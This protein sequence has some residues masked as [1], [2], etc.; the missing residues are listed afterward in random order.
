MNMTCSLCGAPVILAYGYF[1]GLP[2]LLESA[3]TPDGRLA[4][5]SDGRFDVVPP[6]GRVGPLYRYHA[7]DGGA[8]RH[9]AE[10]VIEQSLEECEECASEL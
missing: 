9:S 10:P 5:G 2:C 8:P 7:C 6:Q 1:S 3:P 4:L